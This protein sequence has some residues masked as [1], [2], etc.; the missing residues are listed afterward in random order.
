MNETVAFE[1]VCKLNSP[2]WLQ[3]LDSEGLGASPKD[4]KE[5]SSYFIMSFITCTAIYRYAK[6]IVSNDDCEMIVL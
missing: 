4:A 2:R 6:T 5:K 1:G 3:T